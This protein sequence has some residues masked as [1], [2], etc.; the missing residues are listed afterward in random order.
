MFDKENMMAKK[1]VSLVI[2]IT[3]VIT[4]LA[5][6][7]GIAM[8]WHGSYELKADCNGWEVVVNTTWIDENGNPWVGDIIDNSPLS[9]DWSEYITVQWWF[10]VKWEVSPGQFDYWSASGEVT[11]P[12]D[13][14]PPYQ[15]CSITIEQVGEWSDW[16]LD[17]A[18]GMEFRTRTITYTDS[19]DSTVICDQ[20][21]EIEWR[22]IPYE[23]CSITNEIVGEWSE[24]VLDPETNMEYRT[25]VVSYLDSQDTS[26][27]CDR[28]EEVEWRDV[29]Y[30]QCSETITVTSDWS[31]WMV[32]PNNE[33]EE[34]R[35]R[36]LYLMDAQDTFVECG[37]EEERET[38]PH[39]VADITAVVVDCY[40]GTVSG[41]TNYSGIVTWEVTVNGVVM[42][43]SWPIGTLPF[44]F[45]IVWPPQ[46]LENGGL[47]AI[48]IAASVIQDGVET[49]HSFIE[50]V[51]DCGKPVEYSLTASAVS[52]CSGW[53]VSAQTSPDGAEVSYTPAQSGTV[54]TEPF[55]VQIR[56]NWSG[57][58]IRM[59]TVTVNAPT[60]NCNPPKP[61]QEPEAVVPQ[62]SIPNEPGTCDPVINVQRVN[63]RTKSDW[64]Q[65]DIMALFPQNPT[66]FANTTTQLGNGYD[67]HASLTWD[68][69]LRVWQ[70]TEDTD[71]SPVLWI[72]DPTGGNARRLTSN[73]VDVHGTMAD[74]GPNR[75]I[76][77]VST[78]GEVLITDIVGSGPR[79]T[80]IYCS[81]PDWNESLEITCRKDGAL[82]RFR[83]ND[84]SQV[85]TVIP[86]G[87]LPHDDPNSN[88]TFFRG[89]PFEGEL[90]L[91]VGKSAETV[92]DGFDIAV[93]PGT[94]RA[95]KTEINL[96]LTEDWVSLD[97][98]VVFDPSDE[99][100]HDEVHAV[101][102]HPDWRGE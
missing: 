43:D 101:F 6:P 76:A 86:A 10:S 97:G 95:L 16:T 11:K 82:I 8:A 12:N 35:T 62:V 23:V 88:G 19:E 87:S 14:E 67:A 63:F 61:P 83:Y 30:L 56:A 33:N 32:D 40:S 38:R 68:A 36:V 92:T 74:F 80:G 94:T 73:G 102:L 91:N 72:S 48:S 90:S 42:Q 22:D 28:V 45:G 1:L 34:Y 26:V 93:E 89:R 78:N 47:D 64:D 98:S 24:W 46:Y 17:E 2:L 49:A 69:C 59:I 25:R 51:F 37:S 44:E 66:V 96:I 99:N 81:D 27:I 41:R 9:G 39:I 60:E 5:L 50:G 57:D 15:K 3:I 13:C 70:R 100:Q 85:E 71:S 58:V 4:G 18:S 55:D 20:K 77:F 79:P 65:S 31:E 54:V 84:P 52:S 75:M 7:S 21:E 53:N 29:P